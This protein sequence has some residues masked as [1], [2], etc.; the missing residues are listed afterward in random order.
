MSLKPFRVFQIKRSIYSSNFSL[1][2]AKSRRLEKKE[3]EKYNDYIYAD[4]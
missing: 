1:E 3:C 4:D 2:V